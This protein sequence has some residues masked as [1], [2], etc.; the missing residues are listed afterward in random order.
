MMEPISDA[1]IFGLCIGFFALLIAPLASAEGADDAL[2]TFLTKRQRI[3]ARERAMLAQRARFTAAFVPLRERSR[4]PRPDG[5]RPPLRAQKRK[6]ASKTATK[7]AKR[8]RA[9]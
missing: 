4:K 6:H 8:R 5:R 1:L 7:A 9:T 2:A 3:L